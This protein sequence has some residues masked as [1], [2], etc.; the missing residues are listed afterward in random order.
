MIFWS[1]AMTH[2]LS[3]QILI[4]GL[5][6][7]LLLL[8]ALHFF[9][10]DSMKSSSSS[11]HLFVLDSHSP[12]ATSG[13]PMMSVI[14][15]NILC[16][17]TSYSSVVLYFDA[18]AW[19]SAL[20]IFPR[21]EIALVLESPDMECVYISRRRTRWT[22]N[23][24]SCLRTYVTPEVSNTPQL[25]LEPRSCIGD[26]SA[27]VVFIICSV[28]ARISFGSH[29]DNFFCIHLH[30]NLLL[31]LSHAPLVSTTKSSPLHFQT[32][33]ITVRSLSYLGWS[34]LSHIG[35]TPSTV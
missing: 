32:E 34:K 21:R 12:R 10:A 1:L 33:R 19:T 16:L 28:M 3:S 20:R 24:N 22:P 26:L 6:T 13:I 4:V 27:S 2:L 29:S 35:P 7:M 8:N 5:H 31:E 30:W 9:S 14:F 18:Y 15:L 25:A 17:S 11:S 23:P